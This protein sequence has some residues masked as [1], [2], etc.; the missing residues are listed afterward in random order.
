MNP[1]A[2][3]TTAI[4]VPVQ[5][6]PSEDKPAVA[7]KPA[8]ERAARRYYD[9]LATLSQ[10]HLEAVLKANAAL[11]DGLEAL[12][13]EAVGYARETLASAGMA[14]KDLLEARTLDRVIEINASLAK[15]GLEALVE[16]TAR[17]SELSLALANQ[18]W[19]PI[20][21]CFE[22]TLARLAKPA[23]A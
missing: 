6:A 23:A 2:R 17:F 10:N 9:E 15:T 3:K 14:T 5:D 11:A 4:D 16:R 7:S 12:A 13:T 20:G 19:A 8:S 1:K 21:G 18:A 22:A